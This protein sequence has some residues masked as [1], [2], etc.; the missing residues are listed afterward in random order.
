M[1]RQNKNYSKSRGYVNQP[2]RLEIN[3]DGERFADDFNSDEEASDA[4]Y[5]DGVHPYD[6]E[7]SD[8]ESIGG[9][10]DKYDSEDSFIASEDDDGGVGEG[11][12]EYFAPEAEI[13]ATN[14]LREGATRTRRPRRVIEPDYGSDH[15]L[16]DDISGS[17][18]ASDSDIEYGELSDNS[19]E[20]VDTE[21]YDVLSDVSED[22]DSNPFLNDTDESYLPSEGGDGDDTGDSDD[23]YH[24]ASSELSEALPYLHL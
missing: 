18:I 12:G 6:R 16:E 7:L 14:I 3:T 5:G 24:S 1:S 10:S 20:E 21:R 9:D 17:D 22:D 13:S 8:N 23:E 11:E 19:D 2:N 4:A 15:I